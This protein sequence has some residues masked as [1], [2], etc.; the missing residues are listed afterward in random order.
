[1]KPSTVCFGAGQSVTMAY[2][3]ALSHLLPGPWPIRPYSYR[4]W[5]SQVT[6]PGHP[7]EMVQ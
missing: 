4:P 1:M 5:V 6:G 2:V 3:R 7:I